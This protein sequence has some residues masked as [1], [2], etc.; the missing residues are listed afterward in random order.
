LAEG[1][2]L[3]AVSGKLVP[4]DADAEQ[5]LSDVFAMADGGDAAVGIKGIAVPLAAR[6]GERYVAHVLPLTSGARRR[7]RASYAAAAA[8]FVHKAALETRSPQE[9]IGKH[10]KLT[11]TELRVLLA[12]VQVDSVLE[13]AEALGIAVSTVKT[14]LLRVFAKTGTRRQA[15]L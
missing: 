2:L 15:D 8:V 11:P 3:R 9:V 12:T 6:N 7:T 14:H 5:A 13:V 1:S 4:N 10:Y